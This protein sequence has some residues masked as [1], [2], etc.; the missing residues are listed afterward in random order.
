MAANWDPRR[1]H[2]PYAERFV[3]SLAAYAR[4]HLSGAFRH[5]P[6]VS[7]PPGGGPGGTAGEPAI[8]STK[9]SAAMRAQ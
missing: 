3:E 4:R 6:P 2:A 1:F 8:R 5:A 9:R 7:L